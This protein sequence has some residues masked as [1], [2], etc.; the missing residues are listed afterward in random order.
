MGVLGVFSLIAGIGSAII[1]GKI[2][3]KTRKYLFFMRLIPAI[4]L[5]NLYFF[6]EY[7]L[8]MCTT[9]K[10]PILASA[11]V[12]GIFMLPTIPLCLSLSAETTFPLNP[13]TSNSIIFLFGQIGGSSLSLI[14]T[15]MSHQDFSVQMTDVQRIAD[16]QAKGASVMYLLF[17]VTFAGLILSLFV[18]EDLRRTRFGEGSNKTVELGK[19]VQ[20]SETIKP[21]V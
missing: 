4:L 7:G 1:F 3:D 14:A 18:E 16:E 19:F 15:E 11:L 13:S 20:L 10:V 5:I 8:P 12:F 6:V 17:W 2:L 9:D 21:Q